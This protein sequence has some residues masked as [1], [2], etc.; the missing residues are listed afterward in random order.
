M[1]YL[2]LSILCALAV[3]G[4]VKARRYWAVPRSGYGVTIGKEPA[5]MLLLR[6]NDGRQHVL[7]WSRLLCSFYEPEAPWEEADGG[8]FHGKYTPKGVFEQVTLTFLQRDGGAKRTVLVKGRNIA[9]VMKA[10]ADG[11]LKD[12][13][14]QP[15]EF[16]KLKRRGVIRVPVIL[17]IRVELTN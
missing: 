12:L 4:V 17:G 6:K 8:F 2:T 5:K 1:M 13:S 15:L 14:E 16:T 11:R 10:I 9:G 3:V 7:P